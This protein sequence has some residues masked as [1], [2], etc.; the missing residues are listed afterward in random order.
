MEIV[1]RLH[2]GESIGDRVLKVDHAGEH[3]AVNIYRGQQLACW[4]R[5]AELRA[6][7]AELQSHE[8]AH[9]GIFAAEL[10]RRGRRRCQSYHL[11]GIG[12]FCLGLVTGICGRASI[13]AA[14]VAVER[15]V[16]RHLREQ[17]DA[18][19]TVDPRACAA[20]EAIVQDEQSHHDKALLE[21]RKGIFWPRVLLPVIG[22]AT[23]SVIWMGMRL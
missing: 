13:A 12:G 22:W 11:C 17:I 3:G 1:A 20:I 15:V 4:W 19:R 18:L 14:T 23:E 5:D 6:A 8:E 10:A 16:L 2:S 7:L 9:R 21:P